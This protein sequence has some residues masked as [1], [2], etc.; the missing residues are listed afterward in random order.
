VPFASS[1]AVGFPRGTD[2]VALKGAA[3][4]AL[5]L[6]VR[7]WHKPWPATVV[8]AALLTWLDS[9]AGRTVVSRLLQG[10]IYLALAGV[11]FWAIDRSPN[12]LLTLALAL[13]GVAVF[14]CLV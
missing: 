5:T 12:L 10:L 13:A 11:L 9:G 3:I 6:S 14:G 1:F 8:L 4:L 2:L 7:R